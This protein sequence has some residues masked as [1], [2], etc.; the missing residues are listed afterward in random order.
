MAQQIEKNYE[1]IPS[2]RD[3]HHSDAKS[4]LLVGPFRSGKSV[5]AVIELW[6]MAMGMVER[7]AGVIRPSSLQNGV[8]CRTIC[9]RKTYRMLE[10]SVIKTFFQWVPRDAGKW[11]G[12]N[13]AFLFPLPS[14]YFWEIL[15]RS[16]ETPQ[17]I[18]KFRGVEITNFWID[19]AQEVSQD[20]KLILEGRLSYPAGA[21]E[22]VFKSVLTTNPC[23]TEH[24][25]YRDYVANPLPGHVYWKQG[26]NENPYLHQQYYDK[27]R[28][29]YRDRP[30]IMRRYVE[31]EWGAIFSGKPVYVQEFNFDFHVAK[32]QIVPVEGVPIYRGWDF[33]LTPACIFTQVHPTGQWTI[34]RELWSDDM[35]VDEFSDAVSDFSNQNFRGFTFED[36]GDPAGRARS[37]TDE[38]SCYDVLGGKNIYVRE[39]PTNEFLPRREAVAR[40]LTRSRKG[41]PQMLIDPRCKRLIDGFSGGYRYKERGS[42]GTFGERPEKNQYSHIHDALQYVALDLFGYADHNPKLWQEP[43]N[44]EGIVNA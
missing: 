18:D 22:G 42:T 17:D 15:F 6:T 44:V 41:H 2:L 20:V 14:G 21:P 5:A 25:I 8:I 11:D 38:R 30:E 36:V 31:G 32:S 28:E 4:R 35:G 33:G 10:D 19:E 26:A 1:V 13:M 40:K 23:D 7:F 24:W 39:A 16:A 12:Q 37:T 29:M 9:V 43:L 3:F 34:L 27:L